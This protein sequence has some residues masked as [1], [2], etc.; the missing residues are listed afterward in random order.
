MVSLNSYSEEVSGN[1]TSIQEVQSIVRQT[2]SSNPHLYYFILNKSVQ[3]KMSGFPSLRQNV[4]NLTTHLIR[5]RMI[6]R[7]RNVTNVETEYPVSTTIEELV[8]ELNTQISE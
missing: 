3:K 4:S 6:L 5:K 2:F 1:I 7:G 8:T